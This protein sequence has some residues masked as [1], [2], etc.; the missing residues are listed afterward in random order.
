MIVGRPLVE[1]VRNIEGGGVWGC[2][3][4]VDNDNLL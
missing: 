3:L 4:K 2:V 1:V